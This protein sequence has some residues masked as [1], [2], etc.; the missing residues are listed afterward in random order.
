MTL[1]IQAGALRVRQ[2][3]LGFGLMLHA[4]Q[5]WESLFIQASQPAETTNWTGADLDNLQVAW[6]LLRRH[7][8]CKQNTPG[9]GTQL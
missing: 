8:F 3:N 9:R 1:D 7:G 4:W 2:A 6:L 5:L